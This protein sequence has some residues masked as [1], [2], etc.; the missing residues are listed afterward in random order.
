MCVFEN[1]MLRK[2]F[3]PNSEEVAT[4]CRKFLLK[5]FTIFNLHRIILVLGSSDKGR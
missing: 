2:I 1:R 5:I 4:G 3:G